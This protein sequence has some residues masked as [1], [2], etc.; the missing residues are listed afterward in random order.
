MA[1]FKRKARR[2]GFRFGKRRSS[3]RSSSGSPLKTILPAA[4]YGA[5]RQYAVNLA[6]P[7]TSMLPLGNYADEAVLGVAGYFMAKKGKGIIKDI[8][9]SMLIVEAASV[10]SQ[11]IG[12][13]GKNNSGGAF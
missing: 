7:I 12:G 4:L 8:G 2:S 5:G 13:A 3:R 11:L 1:R 10:G 9:H 6:T